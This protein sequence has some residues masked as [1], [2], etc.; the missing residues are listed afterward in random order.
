M[1]RLRLLVFAAA[2]AGAPSC[3]WFGT[4]EIPDRTEVNV[5]AVGL[6]VDVPST[7]TVKEDA[8]LKRVYFYPA[9]V[10]DRDHAV[11]IQE[12]GARKGWRHHADAFRGMQD[13]VLD[14]IQDEVRHDLQDGG[15]RFETRREREGH[16]P[17]R[18]LV[19]YLQ[20][21]EVTYLVD[22]AAPEAI[23]DKRL[24]EKIAATVRPPSAP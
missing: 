11:L 22:L 13:K 9:K 7:W 24:Y 19:Y 12:L 16:P 5:E 8:R 1:V 17:V 6:S 23:F 15:I 2:L 3:G 10:N 20:V 18:K 21:G 4:T 14:K